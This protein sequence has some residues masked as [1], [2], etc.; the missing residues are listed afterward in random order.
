[1]LLLLQLHSN[2]EK[3]WLELIAASHGIGDF[4]YWKLKNKMLARDWGSP[5]MSE[6]WTSLEALDKLY[7][8]N[9]PAISLQCLARTA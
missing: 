4:H 5:E 3:G 1:M 7:F 9:I 6:P 2:W 8:C